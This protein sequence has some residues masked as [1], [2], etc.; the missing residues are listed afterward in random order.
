MNHT[1]KTP[2]TKL[3]SYHPMKTS[4]ALTNQKDLKTGPIKSIQVNRFLL[5]KKSNF[6][7]TL[8]MKDFRELDRGYRRDSFSIFQT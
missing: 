7:T 1:T 5:W 8:K 6:I 2:K 3:L 4:T